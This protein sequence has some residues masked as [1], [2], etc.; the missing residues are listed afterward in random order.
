MCIFLVQVRD[1]SGL[2]RGGING[3][4]ENWVSLYFRGR[5]KGVWKYWGS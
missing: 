2:G 3:D 5:L 4:V 1:D